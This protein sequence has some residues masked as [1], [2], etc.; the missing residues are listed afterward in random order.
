MRVST[1]HCLL[2]A[3]FFVA[4]MTLYYAGLSKMILDDHRGRVNASGKNNGPGDC[5]FAGERRGAPLNLANSVRRVIPPALANTE[6]ELLRS[7]GWDAFRRSLATNLH[8]CGVDPRITQAI[9]RHSDMG[10][11]LEF[12]TMIPDAEAR[13]ALQKIEAWLHV[14]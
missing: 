10:T 1:D 11:T 8:S 6:T 13:A 9:L 3:I 5:I 7:K 2:E 14:V 12:Y 4:R